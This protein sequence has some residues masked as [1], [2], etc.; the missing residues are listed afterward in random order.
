MLIA[1]GWFQRKKK[2][3]EQFLLN[4]RYQNRIK[5]W[6]AT[7]KSRWHNKKMVVIYFMSLS[8]N[9]LVMMGIY[10]GST[11]CFIFPNIRD[12]RCWPKI[13]PKFK[14]RLWG[15]FIPLPTGTIFEFTETRDKDN[16]RIVVD[17]IVLY[18]IPFSL[19]KSKW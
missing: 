17:N 14:I 19:G 9:F 15:G 6:D 3:N 7:K 12:N 16:S 5:S 13:M 18:G 1:G 10:P 8:S 11:T 4:W 2:E